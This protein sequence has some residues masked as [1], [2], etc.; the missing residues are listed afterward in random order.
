M[1][2]RLGLLS[3]SWVRKN[4][5]VASSVSLR[6]SEQAFLSQSLES[7]AAPAT[8]ENR[9][10][11]NHSPALTD[12]NHSTRLLPGDGS[13]IGPG[14]NL[15]DVINPEPTISHRNMTI[16]SSKPSTGKTNSSRTSA[17]GGVSK[18]RSGASTSVQP[19]K[20]KSMAIGRS[21]KGNSSMYQSIII[22]ALQPNYKIHHLK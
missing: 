20:T 8:V 15:W 9:H 18:D 13:E 19:K 21:S 12:A 11:N 22:G 16:A 5:T 6:D 1:T 2:S 3:S 4:S 10:T 14:G 7:K 17:P